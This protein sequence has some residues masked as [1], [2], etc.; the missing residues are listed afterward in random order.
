MQDR[1]LAAYIAELIGTMFLVFVIGVVVTLF[2]ATSATSQTGSDF[3]VV[4]LVHAFVL[5][6]LIIAFGQVSGG[7]FNPAITFAAAVMRRIDPVDAVVYI[8]AQLSAPSSAPCWS[9]RSCSTRGGPR[10]TGLWRSAIDQ[11]TLRGCVRRGTGNLPARAR[12]LRRGDEP[13]RPPGVGSVRDRH[14][15]RLRGDDLRPAHGRL[16][17]PRPLVRPG[18][19]RRLLQRVQRL[20]AV[21]D[22]PARRL[23]RRGRW[24]TAS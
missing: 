6:L 18:A 12:R 4:G 20:L 3:A 16:V 5:F 17:Q 24:S 14:D 23:D 1:G 8:L 22:R 9:R 11:R 15:A 2:V 21:R 7:H 19:D 10:T 13:A